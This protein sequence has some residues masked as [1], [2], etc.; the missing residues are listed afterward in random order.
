VSFVD[1][2]EK[3]G[4]RIGRYYELILGLAMRDVK[5]RYQL[6]ILGLYWAVLNPLLMALVWNFVFGTV[7]RSRGI[8]GVPYVVF[9]F[10]NIS[11]W[12]LF[13]N[14]L[15]TAVNSLTGNASL[16]SKLYFPRVI[17]PTAS[18]VARLVD[19]LF[20][21]I[22]LAVLLIFAHV[23]PGISIIWLPVFLVIQLIF[24]LGMAYFVAALN[25]FY[26]DVNQI[27]GVLLLIWM[28]VSPVFYTLDQVPASIRKYFLYNPVGQI[29]YMESSVVLGHGDM[30]LVALAITVLLSVAVFI[31]GLVCFRWMEAAFAEVM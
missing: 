9:L 1:D 15:L 24:T 13:A 30:N 22:V 21:L 25:V 20:S 28:Y 27:I 26:R 7:L 11:F 10:C 31:L 29:V 8:A 12:N 4:H 5:M 6:S 18:V 16:L 2:G 3:I 14:S 19:L 23:R 17:L